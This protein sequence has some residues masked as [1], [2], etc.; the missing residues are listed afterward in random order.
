VTVYAAGAI[1]WREEKGRLL[2]AVI[3]RARYNDWGWPKGKVDPGESLP[4]T[5]VREIKEETGLSI[6]LGVNLGI[7]SYLLPNGKAKEVH[8]WAA[9]VTDKALKNSKF[10]PSE[11]VAKVDWLT[12]EE[13]AALLSYDHDKEFLAKVVELHTKGLLDTKPF[14]VLR[15]G[16]AMPRDKWEKGEATRPLLPSGK[17]QSKAL[18]RLLPAW[19]AK[20]IV[21]SPWERCQSTVAPYAAVNGVEV[22]YSEHLTEAGNKKT[23]ASTLKV[24]HKLIQDGRSTIVCTHRPAL[25][26]VLEELAKYHPLEKLELLENGKAIKPGHFLVI[27]LTKPEPGK[28]RKI[29]SVETYGPL[30]AK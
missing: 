22:E 12:P 9:K 17:K 19:G 18:T 1:C 6:R 11:E 21:S 15:H 16:K 7:Q 28:N 2:V 30:E 26:T 20:R 23:P 25:P 8:Y 4:E 3:H 29:V 14:I 5:A 10:K 13:A 24:I 27:H